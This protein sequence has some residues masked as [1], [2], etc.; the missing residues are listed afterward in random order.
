MDKYI[1]Q[2]AIDKIQEELNY[3]EDIEVNN[4]MYQVYATCNCFIAH[5]I[6]RI[7]KQEGS[8]SSEHPEIAPLYKMMNAIL[9]IMER[10]SEIVRVQ[11][12]GQE[13]SIKA[14]KEEADGK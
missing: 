9:P 11:E 5:E 12:H 14:V 10:Y 1:I 6:K 13:E 4:A 3:S 2:E 7:V 8:V